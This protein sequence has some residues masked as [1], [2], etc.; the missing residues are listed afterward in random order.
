MNVEKLEG[1][2]IHRRVITS[3]LVQALQHIPQQQKEGVHGIFFLPGL[4]RLIVSQP[5]HELAEKSVIGLTDSGKRSEEH[6]SE[7][8]S[9]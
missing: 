4:P 7:L 3:A 2:G 8:Q 1:R 6:T 5:L 9:R